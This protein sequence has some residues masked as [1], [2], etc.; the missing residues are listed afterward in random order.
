MGKEKGQNGWPQSSRGVLIG[1]WVVFVVNGALIVWSSMWS[2]CFPMP[3]LPLWLAVMAVVALPAEFRRDRAKARR[4]LGWVCGSAAVFLLEVLLGGNLFWMRCGIQLRLWP[5]G[6][7]ERL[8]AWTASHVGTL[9]AEWKAMGG[10]KGLEGADE[11]T[12]RRF[13]CARAEDVPDWVQPV[14]RYVG[15]PTVIHDIDQN[16]AALDFSVHG[17]DHG[18]GLVVFKDAPPEAKKKR[19][20]WRMGERSYVWGQP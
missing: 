17:W 12:H 18:W 4:R 11:K 15:Y 16:P 1:A 6:G 13:Y 2:I 10:V 8:E 7:I 20:P 5:A 9:Q 3:F 14:M 19:W